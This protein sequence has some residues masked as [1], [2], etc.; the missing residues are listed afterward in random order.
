[1]TCTVSALIS[2][3]ATSDWNQAS[4]LQCKALSLTPTTSAAGDQNEVGPPES[5][6]W[7]AVEGGDSA[8]QMPWRDNPQIQ[9]PVHDT[10]GTAKARWV[11]LPFSASAGFSTSRLPSKFIPGM[12]AE[13]E[14]SLG[15]G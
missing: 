15:G 2:D 4:Q 14:E 9:Q 13:P 7:A 6:Q 5:K 12:V 8:V 3:S 1:M 11:E 10:P